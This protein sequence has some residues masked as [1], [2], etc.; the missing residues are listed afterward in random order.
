MRLQR[1]AVVLDSQCAA[2]FR[3]EGSGGEVGEHLDGRYGAGPGEGAFE[4][5]EPADEGST[6]DL[7]ADVAVAEIEVRGWQS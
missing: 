6:A 5:A 7:G 1:I 2:T 4:Y 3:T